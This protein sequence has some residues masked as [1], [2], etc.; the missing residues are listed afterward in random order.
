MV[1]NGELGEGDGK[2]V[3]AGYVVVKFDTVEFI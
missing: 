1:S 3:G 2:I